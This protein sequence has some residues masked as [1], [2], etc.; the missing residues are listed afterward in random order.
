M[1]LLWL[2][3]I[4]GALVRGDL[5]LG[6]SLKPRSI[7]TLKSRIELGKT[8][9]ASLSSAKKELEL[10]KD[11][12]ALGRSLP[13]GSTILYVHELFFSAKLCV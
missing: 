1:L 2:F 3:V 8:I 5:F 13:V 10:C 12:T 9:F 7:D 11:P 6:G 4:V